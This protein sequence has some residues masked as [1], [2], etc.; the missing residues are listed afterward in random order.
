[1]RLLALGL[2]ILFGLLAGTCQ[3]G[4][5]FQDGK[6]YVYATEIQLDARTM[7]Y[8]PHAAA[9]L[10]KMKTRVQ[11]A[12]GGKRLNVR[13]EDMTTSHYVGSLESGDMDK[14]VYL[15]HSYENFQFSVAFNGE[16]AFQSL[17]MDSGLPLFMKNV[18]KAWASKFQMN[19]AKVTQGPTAFIGEEDTIHGKC[20]VTYSVTPHMV[21]KSIVHGSDCPQRKLR[22]FDDMGGYFCTK[23]YKPP[24]TEGLNSREFTWYKFHQDGDQK[25]I[26]E[27][28]HHEAFVLQQYESD[29]VS[30]L[31]HTNI[32]M[33][34]EGTKPSSGDI[35]VS[36]ET[37]DTLAFDFGDQDYGWDKSRD[38]RAQEPFFSTPNYFDNAQDDYKAAIKRGIANVKDLMN[39][40]ETDKTTIM[41]MHQ[42]GLNSLYPAMNGMDYDTIISLVDELRDDKSE[43]G[44]FRF[45]VFCELLG[46]TGTAPSIMAIKE[47][48]K[49]SR[50][51]N[52]RDAM[53]VLGSIP[54]HVRKP[55]K[56]LVEEMEE[57]V[58]TLDEGTMMQD[59][60]LLALGQLIRKTCELAG[61]VHSAE[62]MACF[63]DVAADRIKKYATIVTDP[64]ATRSKSILYLGVL[65]N[66]R[67]GNIFESLKAFIMDTTKDAELRSKA[68]WASQADMIA[69]GAAR[70]TL[71]TLLANCHESHELRI[72]AVTLLMNTRPSPAD[73][74]QVASILSSD[75]NYHLINYVFTLLETIADS[76]QPCDRATS[77]LA[78]NFLKY[79]KQ[80]SGFE[81]NYGFGMSKTFGREFYKKKYG[82]AMSYNYYVVGSEKS[83][84][85]LL[86]GMVS[87]TTLFHSYKTY[88]VGV[89]LR[90]EG[91]AKY[92]VRK[93]KSTDPAT[94][95]LSE[96]SDI[97]KGQMGIR[98]RPDQ[99]VRV[100]MEFKLKGSLVMVRSY[101]DKDFAEAAASGNGLLEYVMKNM[102]SLGDSY[103][104]NHQRLVQTASSKFEFPTASGV[105]GAAMISD[106]F[107]FSLKANV[108]RGNQRG[109]LYRDVEYDIHAFRQ[110]S[111]AMLLRVEKGKRSLGI[112][113]DI[114]SLHHIP[115]HIV[116]GINPIRKELKL[117]TDRPP[118]DHPYYIMMHSFNYVTIRGNSISGEVNDL[119]TYCPTC[120]DRMVVVSKGSDFIKNRHFLERDSEKGGYHLH[121]EYFNCENNV[122]PYN[123][124]GHAL[125]AFMPYNKNP[126]SAATMVIMGIRQVAAY[127]RFYPRAEQCGIK[128]D[129]SQS[130]NNGVREVETV[131]RLT[132][133][134]NGERM[135]FE[136][137]KWQLRAV[138]KQKGDETRAYRLAVSYEGTPGRLDNKLKVQISKAEVPTLRIKPYTICL[139][140][141]NRYPDFASEMM[142]LDFQNMQ[143]MVGRGMLQYGEGNNCGEGDGEI[144]LKMEAS[145][146]PVARNQWFYRE[147]MKEKSRP[148]YSAMS[149]EQLP[150]T[151]A[152]LLLLNDAST[153]RRYRYE[154]EFVKV[155]NRMKDYISRFRTAV[156]AGLFPF[157]EDELDNFG[158]DG[159]GIGPFLNLDLYWHDEDKLIDIIVE[160]SQ[161]KKTIN[162]YVSRLDWTNKLRNLRLSSTYKRLYKM[163]I[164]NSCLSTVDSVKTLDNVTYP[165]TADNC[166]TLMSSHCSKNPTYAVF[167]K[168]SD[169]QKPL[170]LKTY[171]GGH[172][173]TIDANANDVKVNGQSIS[174]PFEKSYS[175]NVNNVE[176]FK[177]FKWGST[178]NIYSTA[179]LWVTFDGTHANVIPA[180]S[181]RGEHCGMCGNF[182]RIQHDEIVGKD[183]NKLEDV[184]KMAEEWKWKC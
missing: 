107:L 119:Q 143:K 14:V 170:E 13:M 74:A 55:N 44:V 106:A 178:Y 150:P 2:T 146:T 123:T 27:I 54:F 155:S 167:T 64:S 158:S 10:M 19:C 113:Q 51:D 34:L 124:V 171:L 160:T 130:E 149:N 154:V 85:P 49:T 73:M 8:A 37:V 12:E 139:A 86:M 16:G 23:D 22:V 38:L 18:V 110:R 83:T 174:L 71:L 100:S 59:T 184:S 172:E 116:V 65:G 28:R 46:S 78:E 79:L 7:D 56:Q 176:I 140:Y 1:M 165:Y 133:E 138:M 53:R 99:P 121:G 118:H 112:V 31:L 43:E 108:K 6:E 48:I 50:F 125:S 181:V 47:M 75:K 92:L 129:F 103:S 127:F 151:Y 141:E 17:T 21:H 144:R 69:H 117:Q 20:Q 111:Q 183:G 87:T 15:P 76:V 11:A 182:N 94:W 5:P 42:T 81:P 35:S 77:E 24:P 36:G 122:S 45:N 58:K 29:G 62:S 39:T 67:M 148:A 177:L 163:G 101:D 173:V 142:G 159:N 52:K 164:L 120:K 109:L 30:H 169:G 70:E 80:F 96:L 137:K 89:H 41:K 93:F 115:R 57:L 98:E 134:P 61:G 166:W 33:I 104:I 168:K 97:L 161:G 156:K 91:L 102:A 126:K 145:T 152:C 84:T 105:P 82:Y 63:N 180:P 32:S 135:S 4:G 132:T 157:A 147:C 26:K 72:S 136:G 40:F 128:L 25:A 131:I 175:H 90:V 68:L 9:G 162:N 66:I 153:A 3:A 60:A 95:K 114:V 88:K 179:R